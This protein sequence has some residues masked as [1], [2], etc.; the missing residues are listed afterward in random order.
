MGQDPAGEEVTEL[1]LHEGWEASAVG[2][3]R[4]LAEEGLE[5]SV[6][7]RVKQTLLCRAWLMGAM[8]RAQRPRTMRVTR[9]IVMPECLGQ[10]PRQF[11]LPL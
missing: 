10:M 8:V 2:T 9:V 1:L 4:G 3:M 11:A 5:V 6:D 7:D